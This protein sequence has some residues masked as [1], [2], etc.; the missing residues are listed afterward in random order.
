M[1]IPALVI[2]T[3]A[4]GAAQASAAAFREY[5]YLDRGVA[6]EFPAEPAVEHGDPRTR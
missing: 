2:L 4:L 5:V 3:L 1:R 6:I